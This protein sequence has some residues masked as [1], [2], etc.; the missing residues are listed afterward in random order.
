[1]K[2]RETRSLAWEDLRAFCISRDYY[3]LGTN[4][5]YEALHSMLPEV[6]YMEGRRKSPHA[7]AK[8]LMKVAKDIMDHSNPAYF[9]I[10]DLETLVFVICKECCVTRFQ[11][12]K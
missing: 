1:M 5:D 9:K 12:E 8:D 2:I 11:I 7:T 4:K 10:M 3:T 6:Q